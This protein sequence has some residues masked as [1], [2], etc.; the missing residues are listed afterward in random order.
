MGPKK[1]MNE[2]S[3][4][5]YLSHRYSTREKCKSANSNHAALYA[6][7]GQTLKLGKLTLQAKILAV[8]QRNISK[9]VHS[10]TVTSAFL[11]Y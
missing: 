5:V 1:V 6:D 8:K 4:H 11:Q 9:Q 2:R 7:D 3:H 10:K